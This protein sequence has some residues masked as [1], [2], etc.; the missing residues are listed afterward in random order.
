MKRVAI[1]AAILA[2]A[3]VASAQATGA[4][5]YSK[6]CAMCHGKDGKPTP[7]GAKMGAAELGASKLSEAEVVKVVAEGK[8]KM[9][10][11]KGKMT[12]AEIDLVAKF[13]KAGLK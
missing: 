2:F 8:G 9:A 5:V 10:A 6:R 1:A 11:F 12:D 7:V 4:E 13:V 3:S